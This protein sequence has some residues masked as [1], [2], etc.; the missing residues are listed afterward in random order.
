MF[1]DVLMHSLGLRRHLMFSGIL[2]RSEVFSTIMSCSERFHKGSRRSSDVLVCSE[3]FSWVLSS[4]K[5]L[6]KAFGCS[7]TF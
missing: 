2:R 4:I 7:L 5:R 6:L 3:A 1:C